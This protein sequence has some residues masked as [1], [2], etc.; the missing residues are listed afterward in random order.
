MLDQAGMMQ[1]HRLPLP[2]CPSEVAEAEVGGG[3]GG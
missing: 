3:D 1:I 2:G